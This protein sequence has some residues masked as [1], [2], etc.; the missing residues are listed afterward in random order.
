MDLPG[1]DVQD[2]QVFFSQTPEVWNIFF[3]YNVA[4]SKCNPLELTRPDFCNIMGKD[5]SNGLVNG[6]S[7]C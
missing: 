4:F 6:D 1:P 7:A 3:P 5:F 2:K